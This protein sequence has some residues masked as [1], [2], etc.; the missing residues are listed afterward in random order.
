VARHGGAHSI[1]SGVR[2][3]CY[4]RAKRPSR[5]HRRAAAC[6]RGFKQLDEVA[7]EARSNR[8]RFSSVAP[9][10]RRREHGPGQ[11]VAQ[12]VADTRTVECGVQ[13]V[14][15]L[16]PQHFTTA[17]DVRV[18]CA[19]ASHCCNP[20]VQRSR[21]HT[22]RGRRRASRVEV[23]RTRGV[24]RSRYQPRRTQFSGLRRGGTR[25]SACS[26]HFH[27]HNRVVAVVGGRGDLMRCNPASPQNRRCEP[28][29]GDASPRPY[30]CCSS[31]YSCGCPTDNTPR[32]V[33]KQHLRRRCRSSKALSFPTPVFGRCRRRRLWRARLVAWAASG[34]ST[35][36]SLSPGM[37][38]GSNHH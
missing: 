34:C 35:N 19:I 10:R 16:F 5:C 27:R 15:A 13:C 18:D 38:L 8:F 12:L 22:R 7:R 30:R 24:F 32:R 20:P 1:A 23:G 11:I 26:F 3:F 17:R 36:G 2:E 29:A 25:R 37:S 4:R 6:G 28:G 9:L 33:S 21:T 14:L 31:V